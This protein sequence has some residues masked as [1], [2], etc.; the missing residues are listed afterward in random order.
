MH[1]PLYPCF[2]NL[3]QIFI[4]GDE[5][6]LSHLLIGLPPEYLCSAKTLLPQNLASLYATGPTTSGR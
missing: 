5:F 6:G 4:P 2:K 1:S 3:L